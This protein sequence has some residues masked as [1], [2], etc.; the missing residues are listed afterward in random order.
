MSLYKLQ[1]KN[2]LMNCEQKSEETIS[3]YVY[4]LQTERTGDYRLFLGIWSPHLSE[5]YMFNALNERWK[6]QS[7]FFEE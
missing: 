1:L 2:D 7:R 5:E 6:Q 4:T 3:H